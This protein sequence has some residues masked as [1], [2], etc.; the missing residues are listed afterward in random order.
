MASSLTLIYSLVWIVKP[1]LF[2]VYLI[3]RK[4]LTWILTYLS[5]HAHTVTHDNEWKRN[6]LCFW[7]TVLCVL[8]PIWP[9][10]CD[11]IH[12]LSLS[13]WCRVFYETKIRLEIRPHTISIHWLL[14]IVVRGHRGQ[15]L[16][17]D[18]IGWGQGS[19]GLWTVWSCTVGGWV[20]SP[21]QWKEVLFY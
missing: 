18:H 10:N 7:W 13:A 17:P 2:F 4:N 21:W 6:Y 15:Q 9:F 19:P 8:L 5:P 12:F 1:K 20:A 14:C 11:F 16:I 3:K